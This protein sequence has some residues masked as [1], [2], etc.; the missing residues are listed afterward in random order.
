[1]VGTIQLIFARNV[2]VSSLFIV[3]LQPGGVLCW[4]SMLGEGENGVM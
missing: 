2:A 1:M 4:W 3:A